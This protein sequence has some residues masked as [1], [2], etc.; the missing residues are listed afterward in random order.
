MKV[1][2]VT[3]IVLENELKLLDEAKTKLIN[4]DDS[5][6][7]QLEKYLNR[8]KRVNSMLEIDKDNK[9]LFESKYGKNVD[10]L[11]LLLDTFE[12]KIA[13][14]TKNNTNVNDEKIKLI[15]LKIDFILKHLR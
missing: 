3:N 2:N 11:Y 7:E 13:L 1:E 5:K 14:L 9:L 4:E 6:E 8:F 10:K 12:N 15:N